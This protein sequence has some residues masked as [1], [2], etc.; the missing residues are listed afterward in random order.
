[1][2]VYYVFLSHL[3]GSCIIFY[4]RV[5]QNVSPKHEDTPITEPQV[6]DQTWDVQHGYSPSFKI[7]F[8]IK[9]YQFC[10]WCSVSP[11]PLIQGS[12]RSHAQNLMVVSL[13]F[14]FIWNYFSG[15]FLFFPSFTAL[16]FLWGRGQL[17]LECVSLW[18]YFL[19]LKRLWKG[20]TIPLSALP[21]QC[22]WRAWFTPPSVP[23][24]LSGLLLCRTP[25]TTLS[26]SAGV[27]SR[28]HS[29]SAPQQNWVTFL[30]SP[31]R[32]PWESPVCTRRP[33]E[34]VRWTWWISF[35]D[36]TTS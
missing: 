32:V 1:M 5:L 19:I 33:E 18:W 8:I 14:L 10:Q 11:F 36:W 16:I 28:S 34:T 31:P 13:W 17:F 15:F 24:I 6:S 35:G 26:Q 2:Y 7:H 30:S 4:P 25:V 29:C 23:V 22:P 3:S 9:S 21:L 27:S 12:V 20:C